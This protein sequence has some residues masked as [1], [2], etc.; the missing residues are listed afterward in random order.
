M[1]TSNKIRPKKILVIRLKQIGDALLALPICNSLRATYPDAEIHYLVYQHITPLLANQPSIDALQV[2]TPDE[3]NKKRLYV[4]KIIALRKQNYDLVIDLINVPISAL[5][6]FL[7]GATLTIGFDKNKARKY[8]Y[9]KTVLHADKNRNSSE[10][11]LD[12]LQGL[13]DIP[14]IKNDW[15]IPVSDTDKSTVKALM[16]AHGIDFSR[17]VIFI[18]ASSRRDD[19]LWPQ[20]YL[21]ETINH[22]QKKYKAQV[23][24]N[25]L[26]GR[27]GELVVKL[28]KQLKAQCDV[29]TKIA[30][31]L[32]QVP[33]A[34]SLCDFFF[35]NDGGP[36]HMA[37]GTK[38]PSLV[39]YPPIHS[40]QTWLPV[41]N[42]NHQGIDLKDVMGLSFNEFDQ[43]KKHIKTDLQHYYHKIT[44]T[45]AIEKCDQMLDRIITLSE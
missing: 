27:E 23:V 33:I 13:P 28:A 37:V 14:I 4:K 39:I 21:V 17:P 42:V 8:L 7:T 9:K 15:H 26:A 45:H 44:P 43:L 11:K 29:F 24:L 12:I 34:I 10:V 22:L 30:L 3:R 36:H 41:D 20:N 2:I 6:T 19:K 18:A 35:G 1:Q 16:Q 32:N 5:T 40:K 25:W 38:T 31:T